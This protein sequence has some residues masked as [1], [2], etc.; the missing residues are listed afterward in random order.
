[1]E[2]VKLVYSNVWNQFSE[3]IENWFWKGVK[4]LILNIIETK[5]WLK[6]QAGENMS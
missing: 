3:L 6:N 1:M 2:W 4:P 5:T